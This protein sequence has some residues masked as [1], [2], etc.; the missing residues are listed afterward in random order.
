MPALFARTAEEH[1]GRPLQ[2][3]EGLALEAIPGIIQDALRKAFREWEA[4]GSDLPRRE[5]SVASISFLPETSPSLSR[6]FDQSPRTQQDAQPQRIDHGY[7]QNQYGNASFA[8]RAVQTAQ[9]ATNPDD[10]GFAEGA[11]FTSGPQ[12]FNF[13]PGYGRTAWDPGFGLL[14]VGSYGADVN[15]QGH[16]QGFQGG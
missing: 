2:A 15:H 12:V 9:T 5:A 13:G 6:N 14:G 1:A 4:R 8:V 16:F 11:L 7:S 3:Q 10:S